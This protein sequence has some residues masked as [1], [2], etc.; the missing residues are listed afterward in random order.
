MSLVLGLDFVCVLSLFS[1]TNYLKNVT[2]KVMS[3]HQ[4]IDPLL[5]KIFI[6]VLIQLHSTSLLAQTEMILNQNDKSPYTGVLMSESKF[7]QTKEQLEICDY[8]RNHQKSAICPQSFNNTLAWFL[9][10]I[11]IGLVTSEVVHK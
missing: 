8:D 3:F 1:V 2:H 9:S 11:I 6:I 7:K 4:T 10:G 5:S